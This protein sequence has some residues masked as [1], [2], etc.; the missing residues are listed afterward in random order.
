M[1]VKPSGQKSKAEKLVPLEMQLP[2]PSTRIKQ[3][4][5]GEGGVI[6]TDDDRSGGTS[7]GACAALR[8]RASDDGWLYHERLGYNYR[9][10]ELSAALGV[11]QMRKLTKSWQ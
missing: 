5:T 11:A 10:P 9:M 7:V 4:T 3:I 1:P 6:V 2:L 8:E